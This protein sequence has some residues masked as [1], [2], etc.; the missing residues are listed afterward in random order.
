[1]SARDFLGIVYELSFVYIFAI[2]DTKVLNSF[3]ELWPSFIPSPECS[4]PVGERTYCHLQTDCCVLP[5]LF[6]VVRHVGR[7]KLGSKHS[8]LY[9]RLKIIPLSQQADHVSSGIIRHCVV[10]LVVYIFALPDTKV[11]HSIE[12]L[13]IMLVAAVNSFAR[14]LNPYKYRGWTK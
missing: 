6:W 3:E 10:A 13:C 5:Q 2:P 4:T 7:L 14:G 9:A 12:Q 1:M 8:Q 11:L